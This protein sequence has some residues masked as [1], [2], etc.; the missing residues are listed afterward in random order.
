MISVS[1]YLG[2]YKKK[3][4]LIHVLAEWGERGGTGGGIGRGWTEGKDAKRNILFI[5]FL[6]INLLSLHFNA[7]GFVE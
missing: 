4:S 2:L 5:I 6:Y 1:I 7:D 3:S